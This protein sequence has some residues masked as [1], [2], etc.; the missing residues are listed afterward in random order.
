MLLYREDRQ[1]E[2]W[3]AV[4][5]FEEQYK[6]DALAFFFSR[7]ADMLW[8]LE[9]YEEA[10]Y[11]AQKALALEPDN[12]RYVVQT[13]LTEAFAEKQCI[14]EEI[15]SRLVYPDGTLNLSSSKAEILEYA[16]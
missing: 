2:F 10:D 7:K 1:E 9:R 3:K 8:R 11:C 15:K 4:E 6:E 13:V 5:D 14:W 16:D 12:D